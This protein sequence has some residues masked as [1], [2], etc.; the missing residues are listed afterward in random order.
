MKNTN[1][2]SIILAS[3]TTYALLMSVNSSAKIYKWTD[4][5]GQ[6]HY[7]AQPPVQKEKRIKSENIEDKIRANAGKY[8]P[9]SNTK[10][11]RTT[12]NDASQSS[13][14]NTDNELSGPNKKLIKY[15]NNQ[16]KNVKQ[17]KKNFRNVWVDVKGNKTSLTQ[18]QRKEKVALIESKIKTDC[19]EVPASKTS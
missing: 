14:D 8:R 2:K 18:E 15:C 12:N 1:I 4:S 11:A 5:N 6:V 7:S 9:P 13:S 3:I 10:V 19:A 17:L 16:R